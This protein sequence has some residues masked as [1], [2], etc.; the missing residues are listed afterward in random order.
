MVL[1][2]NKMVKRDYDAGIDELKGDIDLT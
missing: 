2:L 1:D